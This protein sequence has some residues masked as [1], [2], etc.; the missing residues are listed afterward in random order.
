MRRDADGKWRNA[1]GDKL[2]LPVNVVQANAK[3][4]VYDSGDQFTLM[5]Y[6][7]RLGVDNENRPYIKFRTGVVDWLHVRENDI[8]K[9]I[10]VK[11]PWCWKYASFESGQWRVTD[12]LPDD[13][14]VD[15]AL[16]ISARGTLAAGSQT[17]GRWFIFWPEK[18]L[19]SDKGA[20]IFLYNEK[21]G[22]A[23]RNGGPADVP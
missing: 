1:A 21:N 14:P 6:G 18:T 20:Y 2:T 8:E 17:N 16:L 5:Q 11:E 22:Y 12:R 4:L 23:R 10:I 3:C 9:S 15:A 19:T 7:C 13:W